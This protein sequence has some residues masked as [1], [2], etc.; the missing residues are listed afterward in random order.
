MHRALG[1]LFPLTTSWFGLA[2]KILDVKVDDVTEMNP[3]NRKKLE[4]SQTK[5]MIIPGLVEY[6]RRRSCL[7]VQCKDGK[8]VRINSVTVVGR[9]TLTAKE[10]YNGFLS[11]VENSLER[12]FSFSS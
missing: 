8:W 3:E 5:L 12:K 1:H 7:R 10:F 6:S 2:V 4:T 9:K 11:K